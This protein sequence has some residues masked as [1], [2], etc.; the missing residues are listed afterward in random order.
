MS[1]VPACSRDDRPA[2]A[3]GSPVCHVGV[4]AAGRAS[5]TAMGHQMQLGG[6]A[7]ERTNGGGSRSMGPGHKE[8]WGQD[9]QG[10]Q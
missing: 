9:V 3:A 10:N 6:C 4:S 5:S 8:G 2:S 7:E 1:C